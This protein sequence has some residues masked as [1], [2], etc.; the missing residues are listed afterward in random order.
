MAIAKK[1]RKKERKKKASIATIECQSNI[2]L[3]E[4][5][6]NIE[7][8]LEMYYK[9][10]RRVYIQNSE[11]KMYTRDSFVYKTF[12]NEKRVRARSA[13]AIHAKPILSTALH[14]SFFFSPRGSS[15][16]VY[17]S[18]FAIF[19]S[20]RMKKKK[21]ELW[22]KEIHFFF[23]FFSFLFLSHRLFFRTNRTC[24]LYIRC[25]TQYIEYISSPFFS[26]NRCYSDFIFIFVVFLRI[27]V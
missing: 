16:L 5:E 23:F 1:E 10:S 13:N 21:K 27:F 18:S 7:F 20:R 4:I 3:N 24:V 8:I 26:H 11:G 19:I 2:E 12:E 25:C 22:G 17:I 14:L 9:P 6:V 15:S